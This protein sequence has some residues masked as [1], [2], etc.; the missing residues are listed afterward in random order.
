MKNK[1]Q[2][3]VNEDVTSLTLVRVCVC[4]CVRQDLYSLRTDWK[5]SCHLRNTTHSNIVIS[6]T[7]AIYTNAIR[8]FK[9]AIRPTNWLDPVGTEPD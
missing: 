4:A 6:Y 2:Q 3:N 8:V 1:V 5:I 7:T 9:A